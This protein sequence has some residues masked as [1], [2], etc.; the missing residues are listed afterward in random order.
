MLVDYHVHVAAHGEYRYSQEWINDFLY[1][2]S[3]RGIQE[4][5]FS[6]HDEYADLLDID[7]V[8]KIQLNRRNNI[9]VKLGLEVD[10]VPGRE[11]KIRN[12]I[13]QNEYDYI[14]GSV[15]YID[16]WG[17]DHPDYKAG[18][19]DRDIDEIYSQYGNILM[20]MVQSASFD[21]VGHIDLV[22]IWGHRPRKKTSLYYL[23]PVLKAIKKYGLAIEIN[24]A[25]LRKT[26]EEIYPAANILNM[27]FAYNIPITFGSD[28]HHPDQIGEGLGE[29]YRSARQAGY[30]YLVRFSQREKLVTAIEY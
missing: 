26:V 14:I 25:G 6:E 11:E 1:Q 15:H 3:E 20:K 10:Y 29:A 27:M 19:E 24:S 22:K 16:G 8:K 30:K 21:V 17:F 5:G 28:A 7:L 13:L 12:I 9:E 23:E 2:A 18:F 4:I